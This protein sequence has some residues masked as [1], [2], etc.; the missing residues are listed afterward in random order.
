MRYSRKAT[1]EVPYHQRRKN[2]LARTSFQRMVVNRAIPQGAY[3]MKHAAIPSVNFQSFSE[4]ERG[5]EKE[6]CCIFE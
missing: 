3:M 5:K 6:H 4:K 1:R 2:G